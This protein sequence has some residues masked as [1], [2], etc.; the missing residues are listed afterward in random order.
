MSGTPQP[1][2]E[3]LGPWV[4]RDLF[5]GHGAVT[6]W[7]LLGHSSSGPFKAALWCELEA[8]GEVGAHRQQE[9][10]EL[11]ICLSGAGH[12]TV[13]ETRH[14]LEPGR[15]AVLPLGALLSLSADLEGPMSYLIIKASS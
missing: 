4:K 2:A 15:C 5:N 12:A 6:L 13:G 8:G 9:W 7:D 3:V 11:V 1:V 14:R 10:P